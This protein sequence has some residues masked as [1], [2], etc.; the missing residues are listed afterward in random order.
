MG[1]RLPL[2]CA[3]PGPVP[4]E[5][6]GRAFLCLLGR[7]CWPPKGKL[8]ESLGLVSPQ[9]SPPGRPHWARARWTRDELRRHSP[10]AHRCGLHVP[11]ADGW[12]S[13]QCGFF[14][15]AASVSYL[16]PPGPCMTAR[17]VH[18]PTAHGTCARA[19]GGSRHP[20]RASRCDPLPVQRQEL[21]RHV[22]RVNDCRLYVG[23]LLALVVLAHVRSPLVSARVVA[24]RDDAYR[25]RDGT[26]GESGG[27]HSSSSKPARNPTP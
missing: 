24:A 7:S 15:L 26:C 19:L 27:R 18:Q 23:N 16:R 17:Q 13:M 21:A 2:S 5:M 22:R 14:L 20:C 6:P 11:C 3:R 10:S 4:N 1:P 9:E 25:P 12:P 8:R